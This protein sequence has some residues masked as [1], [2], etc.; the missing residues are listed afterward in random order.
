VEAYRVRGKIR[1]FTIVKDKFNRQVV[2]SLTV[3]AVDRIL[4]SEN[5]GQAAEDVL[6]DVEK[7]QRAMGKKWDRVA[8]GRP[9]MVK[10]VNEATWLRSQGA[11]ELPG[12]EGSSG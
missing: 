5:Q 11:L 9:A 1:M 7:A 2:G 8:W 3:L 10:T 4:K 12:M 6:T